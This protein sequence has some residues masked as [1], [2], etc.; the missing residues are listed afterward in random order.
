MTKLCLHCKQ[1]FTPQGK[2]SHMVKYCPKPECQA[3]KHEA[4]VEHNRHINRENSRKKAGKRRV[5][6]GPY[7]RREEKE[8]CEFT[9]LRCGKLFPTTKNIR[10]CPACKSLK[11][12]SEIDYGAY[13]VRCG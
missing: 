13:D 2:G 9:C 11:H 6:P 1:L 4:W 10:I 8:E 3:T 12:Y 7:Q 5:D